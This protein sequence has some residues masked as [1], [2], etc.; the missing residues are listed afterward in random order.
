MNYLIQDLLEYAKVGHSSARES[1]IDLNNVIHK[2]LLNL[3]P[4]IEETQAI[5]K[6]DKLPQVLAVESYMGSLFQNL[7]QNAIKFRKP[8][9]N[10]EIHIT[11]HQQNGSIF[12]SVS[13]NGIGI[14]EEYSEKVFNL[15][16]RLH[17]KSTYQGTGIGLALCKKIVELYNGEI[18]IKSKYAEGATVYFTLPASEIK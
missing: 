16:Q 6:V 17:N 8:G 15:F 4:L 18:W 2:V 13:D 1:E 10:P 3:K 7:I 11:A 9:I 14:E 12:Y 5:I